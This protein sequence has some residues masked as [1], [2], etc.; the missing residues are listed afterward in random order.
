MPDTISHNAV[1]SACENAAA[2]AS[3]DDILNACKL[4]AAKLIDLADQLDADGCHAM[5]ATQREGAAAMLAFS[6]SD[7]PKL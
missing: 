6:E 1:I 5:A 3:S 4:M 7:F 2:S